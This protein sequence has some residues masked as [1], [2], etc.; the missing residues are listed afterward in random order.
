[1]LAIFS[2]V[3]GYTIKITQ[4]T[5]LGDLVRK[6]IENN[7]GAAYL[8]EKYEQ[9]AAY[10]D[11]NFLPLLWDSFKS[12]RAAVLNLVTLLQVRS[13]TEDQDLIKA[14]AFI[15][16]HRDTRTKTLPYEIDLSFMTDRWIRYVETKED[17]VKVLSKRELFNWGR[18]GI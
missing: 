1:M 17:G 13:G 2:T 7:G 18:K 12:N 6:L 8:L 11:K 4:D 10:H 3:V 14:L 9:V 5:K 16:T 15:L